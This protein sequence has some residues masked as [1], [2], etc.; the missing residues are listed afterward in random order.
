M[1]ADVARYRRELLADPA[2]LVER[3]L[4]EL[5][6][7]ADEPERVIRCSRGNAEQAVCRALARVAVRREVWRVEMAEGDR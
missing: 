7:V 6:P 4:R 3:I 2:A 1:N 5:P